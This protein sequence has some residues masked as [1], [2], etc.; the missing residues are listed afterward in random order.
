MQQRW[1]QAARVLAAAEHDVLAYMAFPAEHWTR[2][3]STNPLERLNREIKR[4][5]DVVGVFPDEAAGGAPGRGRADGTRRRVG[6]RAPAVQSGVDAQADCARPAELVA[7]EASPLRLAA[8][9]LASRAASRAPPPATAP[10]A[11]PAFSACHRTAR[12]PPAGQ[13]DFDLPGAV[14]ARPGARVARQRCSILP[15]SNTEDSSTGIR[16]A[17]SNLHNLTHLPAKIWKHTGIYTTS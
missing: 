7:P 14:L 15:P 2:I 5:T 1:P 8:D 9:S 10:H 12:E 17:V 13:P 6:G 4:R 16:M 3:Y 11:G